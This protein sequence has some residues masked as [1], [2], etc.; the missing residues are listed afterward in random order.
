MDR[1]EIAKSVYLDLKNNKN[2]NCILYLFIIDCIEEANRFYNIKLT[3]KQKDELISLIY[4][5]YLDT[6]I[7]ISCIT[8]II[9]SN[10]K[11]IQEKIK[12]DDF[13]IYDY[14]DFL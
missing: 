10:Y 3:E 14:Y 13:N 6:Q 7:Q 5:N 12:E 11:D 9:L 4:D 2:N 1:L 8:D